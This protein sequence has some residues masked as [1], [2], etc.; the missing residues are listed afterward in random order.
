MEKILEQLT[1]ANQID[2][3]VKNHPQES[4]KHYLKSEYGFS[5]VDEIAD[6]CDFLAWSDTFSSLDELKQTIV[7]DDY[8]NETYLEDSSL[9]FVDYFAKEDCYLLIVE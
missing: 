3:V 4:L 6:D 5:S 9:F 8:L 2:L 7:R 1:S